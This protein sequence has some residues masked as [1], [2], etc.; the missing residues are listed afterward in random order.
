MNILLALDSIKDFENSIEIG[1]YFK[2]ELES[3]N[4]N[5]EVNI[6]PFLDGGMGTVE[7]MKEVIG[8]DFSYVNVHNPLSEA[9]TSRYII[10]EN[11]CVME[12]AQACGLRLLYKDKLDVMESSSIGL[13]EMIVDGLN[14]GCEKFFI[15]IG[16]TATNDMGMGM[17]YALG[18]RFFDK[19]LNS[20][21]PVAK[22]MIKVDS[23]DMSGLD[24]RIM[25]VDLEIAT[26]QPLTLFQR[27]SFLEK[28]PIRK[29]ASPDEIL[30]LEKACKHFS[31]KVSEALGVSEIDFPY[32]GAGGGVSWALYIFFRAKI[33]NSMELVLSLLDFQ[34]LVRD[35]DL[36]IITEN[37]DEFNGENSIN[38][39]K[40]AKRY[41]ENIKIIFLQDEDYPNMRDNPYIDDIYKFKIKSNLERGD[42]EKE[43][44]SV[45]RTFISDN[46]SQMENKFEKEE[47]WLREK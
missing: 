15:G 9:V 38:L 21:N 27:N 17:L 5:N 46:L 40:F 39:S 43:I 42:Y 31:K 47:L 12:M 3:E 7:I 1:N 2:E 33:S 35:K 36:L 45:A 28:R 41:N 34:K 37:V 6:L 30:Q 29:G 10:K 8:G 25:D 26:S 16:D 14:N 22:N 11:L 24:R 20:L 4:V 13:G 19:N 32:L 18:V 23:I 44:R